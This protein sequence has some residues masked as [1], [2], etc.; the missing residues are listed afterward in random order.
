MSAELINEN[1]SHINQITVVKRNRSAVLQ[2][3]M[4]PSASVAHICHTRASVHTDTL[5]QR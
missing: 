3:M 2:P 1:Y 5:G 4:M